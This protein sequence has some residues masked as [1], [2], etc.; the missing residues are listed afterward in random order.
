MVAA[1]MGSIG[2]LSD[3]RPPDNVPLP[4]LALSAQLVLTPEFCAS[5]FKKGDWV[6]GKET[7]KVGEV[8]CRELEPALKNVFSKLSIASTAT[9]SEGNQ[10]LL[11]PR[12]LDAGAT[13]TMGAFSNRQM[14]V[15]LE[16]TVKDAAGNTLWL[17]TVKGS[18]KHHTGN[19]ITYKKSFKAIVE[20]STR[21]VAG[22]SANRM[23][24]SP[25]LRKLS[26]AGSTH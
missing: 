16:W 21:D 17:E 25:E 12:F 15:L 10:V 20:E 7:F 6:S 8:A 18:A 3:G 9:L 4:P 5:E 19:M 11:I 14:D 2:V 13:K 26:Q 22:E 23:S 24:Q 1:I